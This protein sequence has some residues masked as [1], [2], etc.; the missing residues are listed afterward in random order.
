MIDSPGLRIGTVKNVHAD[1]HAIDVQFHE[2][3]EIMSEVKIIGRVYWNLQEDDIVLIGFINGLRDNPII[4]DK[5]LMAGDKL[6]E[7]S[8]PDDIHLKHTVKD[9]DGNV[10]GKIEVQTDKD[11]NLSLTLSGL[12]GGLSLNVKGDEGNLIVAITGD[13][14]IS[15]G[16]DAKLKAKGKVEVD[17][18][19]VELGSNLQKL[20]LN[21]LPACLFTGAKHHLGLTNVKG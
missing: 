2:D 17:G 5:I 4:I 10:T 14:D 7:E 3:G 1:Q 12:K 16:G 19:T 20:L 9:K 6:L 15:V 21:N 18:D 11:G 13:A 8:D